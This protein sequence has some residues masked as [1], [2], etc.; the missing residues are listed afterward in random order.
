MRYAHRPH[1]EAVCA[2]RIGRANESS[3]FDAEIVFV[4]CEGD[5]DGVVRAAFEVA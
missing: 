5:I 4:K 3:G 1:R 2:T